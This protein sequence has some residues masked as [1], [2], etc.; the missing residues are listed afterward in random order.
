MKRNGKTQNPIKYASPLLFPLQK[1]PIK[2]GQQHV[3][4]FLVSTD[5]QMERTYNKTL[6]PEHLARTN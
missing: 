5:K 6:K 2:K 3:L 1:L 4:F